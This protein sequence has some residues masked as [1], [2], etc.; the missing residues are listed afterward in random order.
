MD[1]INAL[2]NSGIQAQESI[3]EAAKQNS[4]LAQQLADDKKKDI[5]D[6]FNML[7]AELLTSTTQDAIK[8]LGKKI[9]SNTGIKSFEKLGTE[10]LGKTLTNAGR[11][12]SKNVI[13]KG[14]QIIKDKIGTKVDDLLKKGKKTAVD[15]I[16]KEFRQRGLGFRIKEEDLNNIENLKN[17]LRKTVAQANQVAKKTVENKISETG[18]LLRKNIASAG[19]EQD[20]GEDLVSKIQDK[21]TQRY[22]KAPKGTIQ[23]IQDDIRAKQAKV[24]KTAKKLESQARGRDT[25]EGID[26]DD[27]SAMKILGDLQ[28]GKAK[29]S[30]KNVAT[31]QYK[32]ADAKIENIKNQID[33]LTTEPI[34]KKAQAQAEPEGETEDVVTL[35]KD[36]NRA[37][38]VNVEDLF[39]EFNK[40]I[41]LGAEDP[42][43]ELQQTTKRA[44]E[45]QQIK[46]NITNVPKL[47][48]RSFEF[49]RPTQAQYLEE[50]P[51]IPGFTVT[52]TKDAKILRQQ[53][54]KVERSIAQQQEADLG[55]RPSQLYPDD[56]RILDPT[57]VKGKSAFLGKTSARVEAQVESKGEP[58][59]TPQPPRIGLEVQDI[60][61]PG[62]VIATQTEPTLT[63]AIATQTPP[64]PAPR[65]QPAVRTQAISTQTAPEPAPR[66]TQAQ[67]VATQTAETEA[68]TAATQTETEA[69]KLA[70]GLSKTEELLGTADIATGGSDII[71]DIAEGVLGI[72][73]LFLP[74]ALD[75]S[76][77]ISSHNALFSSSFQ[78]GA[79]A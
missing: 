10:D 55:K 8:S 11:E 42:I 7:G 16:N 5:Q 37:K 60:Q 27:K 70:S 45:Q 76:E 4:L 22:G 72:T 21:I 69:S 18:Q 59:G 63:Q 28:Q 3:S 1:S 66:P 50:L 19:A 31:R 32:F 74:S 40:P 24:K 41:G 29:A 25:G 57:Q 20:L 36:S 17:T 47:E 15:A 34:T 61:E 53:R 44:I 78:A 43:T 6:P 68:K 26:D 14:G 23:K 67:A 65:P 46:A 39:N 73:S 77:D 64:E 2:N 58:L 12:L 56:P 51:D 9:A 49:Q 38:N 52:E 13:K 54:E 75:K 33:N 35:G 30:I 48:P 71:G 62:Q 79:T